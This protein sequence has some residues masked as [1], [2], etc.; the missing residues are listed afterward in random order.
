M[1]IQLFEPYKEPN[2]ITCR[3]K[4]Q[5][6]IS[7]CTL[8]ENGHTNIAL[9]LNTKSFRFTGLEQFNAL[10]YEI[11]QELLEEIQERKSQIARAETESSQN[12]MQK[13]FEERVNFKPPPNRAQAQ[14]SHNRASPP[15]PANAAAGRAQDNQHSRQPPNVPAPHAQAGPRPQAPAGAR[16]QAHVR[17]PAPAY[18]PRVQHSTPRHPAPHN[19]SFPRPPPTYQAQFSPAA[20]MLSTPPAA[21]GFSPSNAGYGQ[22]PGKKPRLQPQHYQAWSQAGGGA[23]SQSRAFQHGDQGFQSFNGYGYNIM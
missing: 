12:F 14:P 10:G 3:L 20:S 22:Q 5:H 6:L 8:D 23:G 1:C 2:F 4:Q 18:S 13:A 7:N 19:P 16:P 21:A 15:G 9:R 11:P 17:V